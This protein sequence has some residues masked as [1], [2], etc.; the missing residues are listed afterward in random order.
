M[1]IPHQ[2]PG[3]QIRHD[4]SGSLDVVLTDDYGSTVRPGEPISSA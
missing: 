2:R 3:D 4:N 1:A